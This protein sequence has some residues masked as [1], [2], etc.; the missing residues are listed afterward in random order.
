MC[1]ILPDPARREQTKL[2]V[3]CCPT[4]IWPGSGT[5]I[6]GPGFLVCPEHPHLTLGARLPLP[7]SEQIAALACTDDEIRSL[8]ITR[9]LLGTQ[10]IVL[11]HRTDCGMLT[12]ADE[13]FGNSVEQEV[14]VRPPWASQASV[15][16]GPS[17]VNRCRRSR[18][19]RSSPSRT[20]CVTSSSTSPRETRRGRL[21][22]STPSSRPARRGRDERL[23]HIGWNTHENARRNCVVRWHADTPCRATTSAISAREYGAALL[24]TGPRH[25]R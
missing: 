9:R 7:P 14:G 15:T 24:V 3:S 10:E 22:R 1:S 5:S 23:P 18:T 16:S 8:A 25:E 20:A 21:I 4:S 19:A 11:I 6:C 12:S 2:T 13:A 17:S